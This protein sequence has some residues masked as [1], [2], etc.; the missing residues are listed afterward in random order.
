VHVLIVEDDE[1]V[2]DGLKRGLEA[3]E[4]TVDWVTSASAADAALAMVMFDVV[5][6]DL[7][8]PDED[9]LSQLARWRRQGMDMPVL[10]L[11]ARDAVPERVQ[12]LNA[13]A[14]DYLTK[15]F[16]LEELVARLHSLSRRA[17]GRSSN[18]MHY[19]NLLF[20]P[21]AMKVSVNGEAVALSRRE[22]AV[23]Q[24]LLKQP[25]RV[26]S[27]DQLQDHVYGWS[28]GVESN[29]VAVHVHNLRNKLGNDLIET[30]RGLG[31]RLRAISP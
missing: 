13:G 4:Q 7:G 8:L 11:T 10:I 5:V 12:G 20:D 18:L 16:D 9:G 27:A 2:G 21:V 28:D 3:L 26:L 23:L 25:G 24:A 15:P 14:D 30:V 31:Y 17:S 19:G 22:L 29:A 6:L 1:L